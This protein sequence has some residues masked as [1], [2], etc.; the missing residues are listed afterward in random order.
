VS[1]GTLGVRTRARASSAVT[2][3][4]DEVIVDIETP[5]LGDG[6]RDESEVGA[7]DETL[8]ERVLE[9]SL[10][11]FIEGH[12]HQARSLLIQSMYGERPAK[13]SGY[14]RDQVIL[15]TAPGGGN[16]E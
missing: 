6:G 8:G 15:V 11:S 14:E 13:A 12:E 9:T 2:A 4:A 1:D 5:I 16:R 7:R 3:V 10:S